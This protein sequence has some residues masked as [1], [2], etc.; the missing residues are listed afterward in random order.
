MQNTQQPILDSLIE[1]LKTAGP[2]K[3]PAI[4][5]ATGVP[6]HS[7]RKLAYGDRKNP[8]LSAAQSLLD[9]FA[10]EDAERAKAE[11]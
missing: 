1:R 10:S 4:S 11:A 9:F 3:W 2:S 8:R 6:Y 5:A 7:I